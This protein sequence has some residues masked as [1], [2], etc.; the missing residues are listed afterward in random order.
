MPTILSEL[1]G[2]EARNERYM[3]L[4]VL[5]KL[6]IPFSIA[7]SI[8]FA[9]DLYSALT[10]VFVALALIV[11]AGIPLSSIKRYVVVIGSLTS[12]IAI[13]LFL[14]ARIPGKVLFE[15]CLV[16]FEAEKGVFEWKLYITDNAVMYAS[17][18]VSRIFAM[19]LS[20]ML[21]LGTITDR[22]IVWGLRS[23]GLPFGASIAVS[24]F[25]RGIRLFVS[26]FLSIREAMTA[27]GVD[28]ARESLIKKFAL[29][30]HA[31]IPLLALMIT[32]SY[33][34]SLALET[35]GIT[36]QSKA[37]V[38]YHRYGF[39]RL[40]AALM[41]LFSVLTSLYALGWMI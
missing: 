17:V 25:F 36:P 7:L 34:V 1:S 14:F 5:T 8:L 4:H 11:A 16:R 41:L 13:S 20:A 15:A 6:F 35:R 24:L 29:Y 18:F 2:I 12:F 19:V 30:S 22:E 9:S 10:L 39:S 3:S 27:R 38:V 33:E 40:D 32:R 28:F 37:K 23:L 21:L 31:L 26:D